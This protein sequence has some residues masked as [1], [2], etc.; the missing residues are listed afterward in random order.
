MIYHVVCHLHYIL[1][2]SNVNKMTLYYDIVI[3]ASYL[4]DVG[5]GYPVPSG[6]P[7]T[8]TTLEAPGC[9]H[10]VYTLGTGTSVAVDAGS[11]ASLASSV[12]GVT[13]WT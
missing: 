10:T 11:S 1:F 13:S 9:I 4:V 7:E 2:Q 5:A 3:L 6:A 12:P 8:R